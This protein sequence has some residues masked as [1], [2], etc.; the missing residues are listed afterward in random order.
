MTNTNTFD[1]IVKCSVR[2]S[3]SNTNIN[4]HF[5]IIDAHEFAQS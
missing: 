5:I 4:I 2:K 3:A 1:L